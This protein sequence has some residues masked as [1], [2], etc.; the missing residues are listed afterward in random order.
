LLSVGFSNNISKTLKT[1]QHKEQEQNK[2]QQTRQQES[3][4]EEE[5]REE[6]LAPPSALSSLFQNRCFQLFSRKRSGGAA[7]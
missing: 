3:D 5:E 2:Q 4:E 1:S 6:E 7:D